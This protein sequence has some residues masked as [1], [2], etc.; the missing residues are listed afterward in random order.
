M[1]A[2]CNNFGRLALLLLPILN[3]WVLQFDNVTKSIKKGALES[4]SEIIP[5]MFKPQADKT[6]R[7]Q[8]NQ[9]SQNL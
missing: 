8:L 5:T 2:M 1:Y 9:L 4:N 6:Q 7:I 3:L